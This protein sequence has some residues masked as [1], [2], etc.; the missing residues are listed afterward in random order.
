MEPAHQLR[1]RFRQVERGAIGLRRG[2]DQVYRERHDHEAIIAEDEPDSARSLRLDDA[3][4]AERAG[5]HHAR[6]QGEGQRHFVAHQLR[7]AAQ[8]AE[9]RIVAVRCPAAQ[10]NPQDAHRRHRGYHQQSDVYVR[11]IDGLGERQHHKGG[12]G[13]DGGEARREP[14]NRLVGI[15]RDDVFLEQQLER[16]GDGLQ[17]AVRSHPHGAQAH[18][19][20]G[21]DLPF[22]QHDVAGHQGEQR[23][24]H[25]RH[26]DGREQRI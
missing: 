4:H 24:D 16:V 14:E 11:Y 3:L 25:Q 10:N 19:E 23:D 13:R 8:R 9:Q 12:E 17:Q 26:H 5:H 21:Q 22:H 18:L 6:K 1:F 7:R 20:I 15:R 2:G